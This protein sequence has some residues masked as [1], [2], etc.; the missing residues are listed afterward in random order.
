MTL[1]QVNRIDSDYIN[2]LPAVQFEGNVVVVDSPEQEET[3]VKELYNHPYVG[4]DTESKP[5]FKKG[6]S[7]PISLLQLATHDTAYLF[8]LKKTGFSDALAAFLANENYKK[9]GIGVNTDIEK[10]QELKRF[11]PR[12]FIDLSK[13]AKDKGI[14]QVGARALT[15][16]YLG[17]RLVKTAQK[18][19]WAQS[20]LSRKQQVYAAADAWVCLQVYPH[21]VADATDYRKF[22]EEEEEE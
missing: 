8:Q 15:A 18:T 6:I 16:R 7:Y 5:A 13:I 12:G 11:I 22:I 1:L 2:S 20:Q 21:L 17:R 14:I 4:F 10:L 3:V 19:N 9:I